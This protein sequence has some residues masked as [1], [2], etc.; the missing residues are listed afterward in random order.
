MAP[1]EV[2]DLK[3]ITRCAT[4]LDGTFVWKLHIDE[5]ASIIATGD[6]NN[7]KWISSKPFELNNLKWNICIAPFDLRSNGGKAPIFLSLQRM[8]AS[9]SKSF[10]SIDWEFEEI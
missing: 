5:I 4:T 3:L 7:A 2:S 8:P 1:R 6:K 9:Y 10:I